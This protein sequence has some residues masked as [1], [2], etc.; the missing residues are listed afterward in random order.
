M[1]KTSTT[2]NWPDIK[3][4]LEDSAPKQGV[5]PHCGYCPHCGRGGYQTYPWYPQEPWY[6]PYSPWPSAPYITWTSGNLAQG[7]SASDFQQV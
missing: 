3:K 6:K 2:T 1:D 7:S 4:Q 5:C